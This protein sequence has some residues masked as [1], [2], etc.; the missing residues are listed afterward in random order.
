[1]PQNNLIES[2]ITIQAPLE[3]VWNIL[4]DLDNYHHWNPFT[5]KIET[6]RKIGA[7][8]L[9]HV[10]LHPNS[11]KLYLQKEQLLRWEEKSGMDWG[12]KDAWYAKTIRI[13]Q[14][15]PIDA[16]TTEY[17]T[18]DLIEGPITWLIMLLY[19]KKIQQGFDDVAQ[20]LKQYA[21]SYY[22]SQLKS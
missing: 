16:I 19:R 18:S 11:T 14:L 8:V 2:K 17:Y 10:R 3:V 22:Q 7:D 20:G 21:E 12:I 15:S 1:M 13:Q 6:T 9:L 4:S 5:P